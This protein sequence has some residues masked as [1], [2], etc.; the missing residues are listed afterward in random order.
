M[1]ELLYEVTGQIA[2]VTL[3]REAARNALSGPMVQAMIAALDRAEADPSVRCVVLTGA[4]SRVFCAGAD[5]S[6]LQADGF[7]DAHESRRS[8]AQML[9][10]FQ[11]LKK[12]T[13]ARV[14][15]HALAGGVGLML[16]CDLA[17]AVDSAG[18]GVPEID[19]GLFPMM[20]LALLQRH[21]G[22][23]RAL[24][25]LL[26]GDRLTATQARDWGL[27]NRVVP[28]NQLDSEVN[29][30][31]EKLAGKSLAVVALGR[32]SFFTAEDLPLS[33]ALEFLVDQLSI[34]VL[35]EDAM[36]GVTAFL[37]KRPPKWND[38]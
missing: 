1:D 34:N 36:E 37:E 10:R 2:R 35:A 9:L 19:R 15:G 27:V 7:L 31:A 23:K 24:E 38:R 5:L 3:H 14:N 22:R 11:Q 32:R 25:L 17:V 16:A 30:L 18:V 26:T 20:V 13:I 8:F 28:A 4:G 6:T 12:P 29:T 33:Q 21:V